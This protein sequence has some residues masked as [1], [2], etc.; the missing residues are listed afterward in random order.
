MLISWTRVLCLN[1]FFYMSTVNEMCGKFLMLKLCA[2][3]EL[4]QVKAEE[5]CACTLPMSDASLALSTEEDL[6]AAWDTQTIKIWSL[7]ALIQRRSSESLTEWLVPG[8][9]AVKQVGQV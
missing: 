1:L 9:T 8:G 5:V 3:R 2:C 6:L 4:T 7:S